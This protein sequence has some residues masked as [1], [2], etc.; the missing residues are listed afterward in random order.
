VQTQKNILI[1]YIGIFLA[2]SP[3]LALPAAE[4]TKAAEKISL[5]LKGVE[6]W[7]YLRCSL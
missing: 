1:I 3:S 6:S 5:D 2:L 7:S 4:E